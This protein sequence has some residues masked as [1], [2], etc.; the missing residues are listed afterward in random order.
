M[1]EWFAYNAIPEKMRKPDETHFLVPYWDKDGKYIDYKVGDI[2]PMMWV[3][4]YIAHYKITE[5]V[6]PYGDYAMWDDG[7]KYDLIFHHLS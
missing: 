1:G 5:I 4:K 6:R 7:R 3:G 2:V